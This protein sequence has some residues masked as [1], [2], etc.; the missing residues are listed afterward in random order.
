MGQRA[1]NLDAFG[2]M[3]QPDALLTSAALRAANARQLLEPL[4]Q[5]AHPLAR[6]PINHVKSC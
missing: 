2:A 6:N 5:G 3:P 4:R 1:Q